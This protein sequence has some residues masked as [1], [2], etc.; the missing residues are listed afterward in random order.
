MAL[1][2]RVH[3]TAGGQ[4]VNLVSK[5]RLSVS[6]QLIDELKEQDID[7]VINYEP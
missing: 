1:Y 2:F 5:Q 4:M 7:F 6:R 3:D